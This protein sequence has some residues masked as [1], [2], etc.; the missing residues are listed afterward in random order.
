M[1]ES[2]SESWEE[3]IHEAMDVPVCTISYRCT[4]APLALRMPVMYRFNV[5]VQGG[6]RHRRHWAHLVP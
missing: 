6:G 4:Y 3:D 1:K 2:F 5:G